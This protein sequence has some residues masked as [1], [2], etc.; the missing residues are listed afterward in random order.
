MLVVAAARKAVLR[1]PLI[2]AIRNAVLV[3]GREAANVVFAKP[4][5]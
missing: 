1:N 5:A 4:F 2:L 3:V